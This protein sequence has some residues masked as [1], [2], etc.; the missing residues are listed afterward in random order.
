[1]GGMVA[2][3]FGQV[4]KFDGEKEWSQYA[5]RL[6]HFEANE[7]ADAGKKTAI[8][9]TVIGPSA[10]KLPR[11]LLA[12]AKPI[13]DKTTTGSK[14]ITV[15][16]RHRRCRDFILIHGFVGQSSQYLPSAEFC[17]CGTALEDML[18]DRLVCG[19]NDSAYSKGAVVGT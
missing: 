8:L 4:K 9:L 2:P 17:S 18:R 3:L 7:V 1:M 13:K 15:R 6:D 19:I 10:S 5:E 14:N 16:N 11:N 12:A